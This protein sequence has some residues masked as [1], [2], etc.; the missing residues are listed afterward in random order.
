MPVI[1][2]STGFID[3]LR[4]GAN[5][6]QAKLDV[7]VNGN[8]VETVYGAIS[9]YSVTVDRNAAQRRQGNVSIVLQ[10]SIPPPALL[11]TSTGSLLAPFGNEV[12]LW[13]GLGT[14]NSSDAPGE[15]SVAQW[16]PMGTF[17]IATSTVQ[18]TTDDLVLTLA[19]YDR[20][21]TISQ[22]KL[23][24]NYNLP[25]TPSGNFV[26]EVQALATMVWAQNPNAQPLQ[27]SITPT[28]ATVASASYNQGSDPWQAIQDMANAAGYEVFFDVSGTLTG[29]PIP[30]P[31]TQP[32]TWN[33]TDDVT[34][35][36]GDG[37][38]DGGG[39]S[40][41]LLGSPY[42][43]PASITSTMTRDGIYNDV[44]VTGT[45]TSN[46]PASNTGSYGNVIAQAQDTNP[47]S[48]TYV[49]GGMGN[50]PEFVS[51]NIPTTS[52]QAQAMANNDLQAALS[53]SWQ[54]TIEVPPMAFLDVDDV[55]VVT[56]PR[57]GLSGVKLVIDSISYV[58]SYA[59]TSSIT[60]RVVPS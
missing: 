42:S 44:V 36:Y 33:F 16:I 24:Q 13:T 55:V 7:L 22:R 53:S 59:D 38:V 32:V 20:S 19:L 51:S 27:F 40:T 47:A 3:A 46:A 21:W 29:V 10:P 18:D 9:T 14:M 41:V 17:A 15:I 57:I 58:T 60:G 49:D 8:P 28:D 37:G 34:A 25:A 1:S 31:A 11:P 12:R 48:P 39:G 54:V 5:L 52:A 2:P 50:V 30:D 56:R 6:V 4:F 23:L 26:D 35:L 45:G 43:T